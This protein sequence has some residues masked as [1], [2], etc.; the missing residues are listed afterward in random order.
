MVESVTTQQQQLDEIAGDV[1]SGGVG[2][3]RQVGE[4]ETFVNGAN[5]RHAVAGVDDDA[6]QQPLRVERQNS[7]KTIC[8]TLRFTR[9]QEFSEAQ[10]ENSY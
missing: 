2:S 5:V 4:S 8:V 7:L 1:S 6:G 9:Q 10:C 3:S